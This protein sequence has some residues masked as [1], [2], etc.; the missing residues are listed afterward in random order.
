MEYEDIQDADAR[1]VTGDVDTI[2]NAGANVQLRVAS[3]EQLFCDAYTA[4]I[5]ILIS[6]IGHSQ[7][8][9]NLLKM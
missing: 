8:D 2:D 9:C 5:C 7:R 1:I 6:F 4:S 3:F